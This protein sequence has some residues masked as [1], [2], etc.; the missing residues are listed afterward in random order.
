[1]RL[2]RIPPRAPA[3]LTN[4]AHDQR[5]G[6][7][8]EHSELLLH[9]DTRQG[10]QDDRRGEHRQRPQMISRSSLRRERIAVTN[11]TTVNAT[12]P[13]PAPRSRPVAESSF[14]ARNSDGIVI[15]SPSV[16][17]VGDQVVHVPTRRTAPIDNRTV[18]PRTIRLASSSG[19]RHQRQVED[20]DR[21]PPPA[22]PR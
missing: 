22:P 4:A 8:A 7:A 12:S 13:T 19:D 2:D 9:G 5:A 14:V 1:M 20:S 3:E 17:V 11:T 21:A 6:S 15:T 10:G 18:A 16:A